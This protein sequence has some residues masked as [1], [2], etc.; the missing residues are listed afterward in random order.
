MSIPP[1]MTRREFIWLG[2]VTAAGVAGARGFGFAKRHSDDALLDDLSQGC[3]EYFRDAIA[4]ET[5]ICRDLIHGNPDDNARKGDESRGSTGVTGFALTSLCIGSERKWI[6]RAQAKDLVR[7]ALRSYTNGKVFCERGW[8]YHFIDVHTG[9]RWQEVEMSTS[10][11]IWLLAGALT[12]RQYFHEDHEISDLATLLYSRYDFPWMTNGDGKLLSH[13]WLP[14]GFIKF[15]YDKYCQLAA[16]YL[17]GIGSPTHPLSPEAWY[18]WER[19]PNSYRQYNY[20]GT[21]LLWT[22]QYPFAW[23]DFRGRRENRGTKIDW[24]DNCQIAT[25]AHREW[26]FTDL[27]KQF[28]DYTQDVWGITSSSSPTGYRAWGGPPM[29]SKIDG[30][31]V[32]CA[33]GGSLMLTPDICISAMHAMKEKYGS[34]MAGKNGIWGKH[35][36]ADA[37]NPLTGWVSTDTL[38]LDVGMTLLSTENL[39]SGSVWKWFMANAE[40][41]KAMHLAG[42]DRI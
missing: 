14:E 4:P 24:F 30:S 34:S 9:Q 8:F 19:T 6:P 13:G 22:Y 17:L 15:R 39:R 5:G 16:M 28:P 36:F 21:S 31:V 25:R 12:C 37:F 2:A 32:P 3:F 1:S 38:G 41:Q 42:I 20:I 33:A 35:G 27:A 23:F 11:S 26:C 18:A 7:R 10:D 40:P 29:H